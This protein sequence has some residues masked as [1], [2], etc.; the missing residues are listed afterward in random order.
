LDTLLEQLQFRVAQG[1]IDSTTPPTFILSRE[2][3]VNSN[4]NDLVGTWDPLL[5]LLTFDLSP[6]ANHNAIIDGTVDFT[7]SVENIV[8]LNASNDTNI[9]L[10]LEAGNDQAVIF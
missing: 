7:V 2:N 3:P 6:W 8:E 9:L 1:N 10:T 4:T 5:G